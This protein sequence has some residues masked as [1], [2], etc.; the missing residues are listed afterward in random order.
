[1]LDPKPVVPHDPGV[2]YSEQW[3][4]LHDPNDLKGAGALNFRYVSPDVPPAEEGRQARFG[5]IAT[6]RS[7]STPPR[8]SDIP[9]KPIDGCRP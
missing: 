7:E 9:P 2:G 4:P 3:G 5:E 1:V 8:K 6:G